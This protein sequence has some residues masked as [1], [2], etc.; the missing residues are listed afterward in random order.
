MV[1]PRPRGA[2]WAEEY[3]RNHGGVHPRVRGAAATGDPR[4]CG[5]ACPVLPGVICRTLIVE[6]HDSWPFGP[7][8]PCFAFWPGFLC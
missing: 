1:H 8:S 5:A 3:E 2:G 7:D 6:P 4:V